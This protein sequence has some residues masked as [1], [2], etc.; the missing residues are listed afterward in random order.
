MVMLLN[1]VHSCLWLFVFG[2]SNFLQETVSRRCG[3]YTQPSQQ[4]K[5]TGILLKVLERPSMLSCVH[6][7]AQ[8]PPCNSIN[9]ENGHCELLEAGKMVGNDDEDDVE[10][11]VQWT[12]V[13]NC[14]L[15]TYIFLI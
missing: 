4:W 15:Q 1:K 11:N 12:R 5:E 3:F 2:G 13:V 7:C 8:K 9:F 14:F 10:S 6:A